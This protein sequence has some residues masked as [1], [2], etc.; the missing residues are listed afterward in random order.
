[1]TL[2]EFPNLTSGPDEFLRQLVETDPAF[3]SML[4]V[5][6]FGVVFLG[7]MVA[8]ST[9]K[10]YTDVSLWALMAS[11]ATLLVALPM[12]LKVGILDLTTLGILVALTIAIGVW[13]F[14]DKGRGEV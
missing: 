7:G 8:Q 11:L 2:Y 3:T 13:F 9:R 4:L 12:T 6:V 10:G 14:F 1:M 5:F